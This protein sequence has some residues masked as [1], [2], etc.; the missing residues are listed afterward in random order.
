[1][2]GYTPSIST[3]TNSPHISPKTKDDHKVIRQ[4][5]DDKKSTLR[6]DPVTNKFQS[7]SSCE[8]A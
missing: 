7:E 5:K 1:M 4:Q 2:H 8:Q 6:I 3:L